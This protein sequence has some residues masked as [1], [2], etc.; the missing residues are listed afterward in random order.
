MEMMKL[1][2]FDPESLIEEECDIESATTF[3][4]GENN[5][6]GDDDDADA[7]DDDEDVC[8]ISNDTKAINH[9]RRNRSRFCK[10]RYSSSRNGGRRRP[11]GKADNDPNEDAMFVSD[12]DAD[13]IEEVIESDD[14]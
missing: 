9:L 6:D 11:A 7:F 1:P 8:I 4:Q 10:S 3:P 12:D 13:V 14:E 5:K 2:V